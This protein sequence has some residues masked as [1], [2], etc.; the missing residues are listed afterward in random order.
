MD[1]NPCVVDT[2]SSEDDGMMDT[3]KGN[4]RFHL[5][6]SSSTTGFIYCFTYV[7]A[8]LVFYLS[9]KRWF[10]N[11]FFFFCRRRKNRMMTSMD[12]MYKAAKIIGFF[13]ICGLIYLE[14]NPS[15]TQLP[16][17]ERLH[18]E[19]YKAYLNHCDVPPVL[20]AISNTVLNIEEFPIF[21]VNGRPT[22]DERYLAALAKY[23]I[24]I[25]NPTQPE[26]ISWE[27][28]VTAAHRD[29]LALAFDSN[30]QLEHAVIIEDDALLVNPERYE[31]ALKY[32]LHHTLPFYSLSDGSGP[33]DIHSQCSKYRYSTV[34]YVISRKFYHTILNTC[35]INC[36]QPV[37]ICISASYVL[38]KTQLPIFEHGRYV[39]TTRG[40]T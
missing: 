7:Y 9:G 37:D 33:M 30:P 24:T 6:Q 39:T 20:P 13:L 31:Y 36:D 38:E 10:R 18:R 34:A 17:G 11:G 14:T 5:F 22:L 25:F 21:M 23:S 8:S 28:K 15:L 4:R 2:A 40:T 27:C 19:I 3:E 16:H 35:L 1:I 26:G 12:V 29:I 32:Y